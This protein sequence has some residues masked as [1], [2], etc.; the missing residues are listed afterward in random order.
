MKLKNYIKAVQYNY[1]I[2]IK[3]TLENRNTEIV[4]FNID[5]CAGHIAV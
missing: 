1:D 5:I 3:V 2:R 4:Q